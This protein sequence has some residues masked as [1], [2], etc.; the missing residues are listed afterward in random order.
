MV[1]KGGW[2]GTGWG[3]REEEEGPRGGG[4]GMT[5]LAGEPRGGVRTFVGGG[6]ML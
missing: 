2:W 3:G 1:E 4:G 5:Q 6:A